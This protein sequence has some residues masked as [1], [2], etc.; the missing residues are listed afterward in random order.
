MQ[1]LRTLLSTAKIRL[2]RPVRPM[3]SNIAR[4]LYTYYMLVRCKEICPIIPGLAVGKIEELL[5]KYPQNRELDNLV[6]LSELKSATKRLR[7]DTTP[8]L[9]FRELSDEVICSFTNIRDRLSQTAPI[10]LDAVF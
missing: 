3:L 9:E 6:R 5:L 2:L 8:L 7:N 10:A 1:R 4:K